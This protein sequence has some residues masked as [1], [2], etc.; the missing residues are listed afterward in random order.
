MCI[1]MRLVYPTEQKDSGS[2]AQY[3][4]AGCRYRDYPDTRLRSHVT[5][6]AFLENA[7]IFGHFLF[8]CIFGRHQAGF[9][10]EDIKNDIRKYSISGKRMRPD[11]SR[12]KHLFRR[13]YQ[14]EKAISVSQ[15]FHFPHPAAS[16]S[17]RFFSCWRD[18]IMLAT[19]YVEA[20][21]AR[22]LAQSCQ[23]QRHGRGK[24]FAPTNV[25][26]LQHF[27]LW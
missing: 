17:G 27:D 2:R 14:R 6:L 13:T 5:A 26:P 21:Q 12:R 1:P 7:G 10:T 3:V 4:C 20:K 11:T 16:A 9:G 15:T 19:G 25:N 8:I 24:A 22:V 23:Q 18:L